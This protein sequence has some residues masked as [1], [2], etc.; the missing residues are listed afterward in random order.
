[1]AQ[2][3]TT[4]GGFYELEEVEFGRIYKWHPEILT[5]E[6]TCGKRSDLSMC[7]S[8]CQG[9]GADHTEVIR[10]WLGVARRPEEEEIHPWRYAGPGEEN[11]LP[12]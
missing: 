8:E 5:L 9:C 7:L 10:E 2:V 4:T 6:C 3:I 12:F 11:G 1:M